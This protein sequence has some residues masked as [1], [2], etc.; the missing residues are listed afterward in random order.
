MYITFLHYYVNFLYI[1]VSFY[2][3]YTLFL[4][5]NFFMFF[6]NILQIFFT[7]NTKLDMYESVNV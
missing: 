1:I 4:S 5:F 6:S 7:N 3:L 2:T